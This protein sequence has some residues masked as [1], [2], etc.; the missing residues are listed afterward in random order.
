MDQKHNKCKKKSF[1]KQFYFI[2]PYQSF[3][4]VTVKNH[5]VHFQNLKINKLPKIFICIVDR[6]FLQPKVFIFIN[7]KNTTMKQNKSQ[8]I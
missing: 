1:K 5:C 4:S 8:A 7:S 3:I 6:I 2:F